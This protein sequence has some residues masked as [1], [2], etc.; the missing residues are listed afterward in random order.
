MSGPVHVISPLADVLAL[1]YR[2]AP[3]R[4]KAIARA[5]LEKVRA[6]IN[7]KLQNEATQ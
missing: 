6:L 2:N 4:L 3:P 1:H 7:A 5:E